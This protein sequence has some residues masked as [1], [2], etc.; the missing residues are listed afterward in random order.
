MLSLIRHSPLLRLLL[1]ICSIPVLAQK[2]LIERHVPAASDYIIGAGDEVSIHVEDLD[3]ISDRPIRIDPNGF[4]DLPLIG[5]TEAGGLTIEQLRQQLEKKLAKYITTPQI[6]INLVE[7]RAR[8]FSVIGPVNNPGVHPLE[9]PKHLIEAISIAGGIRADAGSRVVIMR[10]ARWGAL[11]LSVATTDASGGYSTATIPLSDL[12]SG[13]NPS[14]NILVDP[15]DI[16]SVS[17][18]DIVYVLGTVKRAGGFPLEDKD[19]ISLLQALSLAEGLDHDAAPNKARILRHA[20]TGDGRVRDIS[21][22][23]NK[24]I[25]GQNPD[26]PLYANDV[27]YIPGSAAKSTAKRSAE[28]VLAVATGVAIYR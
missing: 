17:R 18:A 1:C 23:I 8:F 25:K 13:A 22:D 12:L 5:R 3:D 14:L 2:P 24:I 15:G 26:V 27:L 20:S 9:G 28:A 6:T 21:I 16:I 19:S 4:I 7:N 10:Q 11:P